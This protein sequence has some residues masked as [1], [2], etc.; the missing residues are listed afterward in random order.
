MYGVTMK[1]SNVDIKHRAE[2]K[3]FLH[4][5][6]CS[7]LRLPPLPALNM[8]KLRTSLSSSSSSY[9]YIYVMELGHLLTPSGLTYPEVKKIYPNSF[10][11]SCQW[12]KFPLNGLRA[13]SR[14]SSFSFW[15]GMFRDGISSIPGETVLPL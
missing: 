15:T 4:L 3:F 14:V 12:L 5:G 2:A 9:I 6:Q 1:F 11:E 13:Q 8:T 7:D 10:R